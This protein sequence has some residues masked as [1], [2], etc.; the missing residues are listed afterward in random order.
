MPFSLDLSVVSLPSLSG[1]KP[2]NQEDF[3]KVI[4]AV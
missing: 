3:Q 2:L 4:E 1:G